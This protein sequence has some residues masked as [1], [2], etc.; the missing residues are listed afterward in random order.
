MLRR[1]CGFNLALML[2][3]GLAIGC[4]GPTRKDPPTVKVAGTVTLGGKPLADADINFLGK[5]YAGIAK[6]DSSGKYELKAQPG[7]NTIY[8]TKFEGSSV[9]PTMLGG[10]DSPSGAKA[11][12]KQLIPKQY[13]NEKSTLK[14]TVPDKDATGADF[15]LKK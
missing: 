1:V 15:D 4:G 5:E 10:G 6:T 12:P 2:T 9:D 14:Y 11:A 3:I 13:A 7:E 8:F